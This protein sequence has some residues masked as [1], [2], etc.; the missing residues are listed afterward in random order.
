VEQIEKEAGKNIKFEQIAH[1]VKGSRGRKAEAEN[2]ADGGIWSA[3]QVVGLIDDI[4]TC[5]ELMNTMM[6]EAEETIRVRLTNM[7]QNN[8]FNHSYH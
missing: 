2:D 8:Q 1:L 3:G 6:G 5:Q 4:P 7:T